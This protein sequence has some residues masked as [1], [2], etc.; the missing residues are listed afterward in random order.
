MVRQVA[1]RQD[2]RCFLNAW[3]LTIYIALLHQLQHPQAQHGCHCG[4]QDRIP[5]HAL[6]ADTA[7]RRRSFCLTPCGF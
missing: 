6:R 3:Q 2:I 7:R 1:H 5:P 4:R